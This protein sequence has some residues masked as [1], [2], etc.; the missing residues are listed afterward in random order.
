M[1]QVRKVLT[2]IQV[3]EMGRGSDPQ[4]LAPMLYNHTTETIIVT[5]YWPD[6]LNNLHILLNDCYHV[7]YSGLPKSQL[8]VS[9]FL[10]ILYSETKI[11]FARKWY[12]WKI[13]ESGVKHKTIIQFKNILTSLVSIIK[14]KSI[15]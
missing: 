14:Y 4:L 6:V 5:I 11:Y 2:I 12:D 9:L 7:A 15:I 10:E 1:R 3:Y 8:T 13:I